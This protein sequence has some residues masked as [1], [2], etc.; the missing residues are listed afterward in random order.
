MMS[1]VLCF[2]WQADVAFAS[3]T[4][5]A[6]VELFTS[7]GCS[8]CPPADALL[9]ELAQDPDVI[10]LTEAVDYWN[11]LGWIDD[12]ARK[13]N[14]ERQQDY[15]RVR[16]DRRIYTPQMV[17]NGRVHVVG[18]RRS[19]VEASLRAVV[20]GAGRLSVPISM[21]KGP[22]S[23]TISIA[24]R[25]AGATDIKDGTLYLVQFNRQI[26]VDITRGKIAVAP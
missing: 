1:A 13:E 24:D 18:S 25:P 26:S 22:E 11:Y 8:S 16:G 12:N 21:E 23:L 10:A 3:S 6:V 4:P 2:G 14:T 17:I 19:E 5:T 7:Q 15:S 20:S 9:S